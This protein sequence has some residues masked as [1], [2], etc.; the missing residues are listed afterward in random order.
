MNHED[1]I[2]AIRD[3]NIRTVISLLRRGVNPTDNRNEAIRQASEHGAIEIATI[4]LFWLGPEY[5]YVDPTD[6]N[7]E[8]IRMASFYGH[9]KIVRLLLKWKSPIGFEDVDPTVNN[10]EAI[11]KAGENGHVEIVKML[12]KWR[13]TGRLNGKKVDPAVYNNQI[14]KIA[15]L[16]GFTEIV[17]LLIND[18]RVPLTDD[19]IKMLCVELNNSKENCH[20][21]QNLPNRRKCIVEIDQLR[22][23]LDCRSYLEEKLLRKKFKTNKKL[24]IE[25]YGEIGKYLGP[26]V[27]QYEH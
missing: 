17:K 14:I 13:G 16:Q 24:P 9:T 23:S 10:N 11:R 26:H 1:L 8:A 18:E 5:Q 2:N 27:G 7:N 20:K 19:L 3:N 6:N 21:I 15:S 22:R 25:L 12:L 4:L